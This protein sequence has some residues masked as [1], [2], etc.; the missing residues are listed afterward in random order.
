MHHGPAAPCCAAVII[1]RCTSY[2]RLFSSF[3]S[4]FGFNFAFCLQRNKNKQFCINSFI[5]EKLFQW[6]LFYKQISRTSAVSS[7]NLRLILIFASC[8]VGTRK[9]T[10]WVIYVRVGEHGGKRKHSKV[11]DTHSSTAVAPH[12]SI[13]LHGRARA[14]NDTARRCSAELALRGAAGRS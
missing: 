12:S 1:L 5:C 2:T 11:R 6:E 10:I 14:G 4:C 7:T 3:V 9:Y 8:V 13:A